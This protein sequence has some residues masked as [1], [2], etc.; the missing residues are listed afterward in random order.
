MFW[1]IGQW[2]RYWCV[3]VSF[4]SK[5]LV[6]TTVSVILRHFDK[7]NIQNEKEHTRRL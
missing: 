2:I 7:H 4:V 1:Y 3:I 5:L 6:K